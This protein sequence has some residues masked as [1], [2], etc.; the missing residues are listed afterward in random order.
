[1]AALTRKKRTS[2]DV[3]VNLTYYSFSAFLSDVFE[4]QIIASIFILFALVGFA[5]KEYVAAQAD[6]IAPEP[7]PMRPRPP[8]LPQNNN[9]N[10]NI[11][12]RV[13]PRLHPPAQRIQQPA[14]Q[15][16]QA[17][18]P[19][20]P[21]ARP[22]FIPRPTLVP[23]PPRRPQA[24]RPPTPLELPDAMPVTPPPLPERLTIPLDRKLSDDSDDL[25][26]DLQ[27][28]HIVDKGKARDN[29]QERFRGGAGTS[30]LGSRPDLK[31]SP[32]GRSRESSSNESVIR[33]S[34]SKTPSKSLQDAWNGDF[35]RSSSSSS[36]SSGSSAVAS[37]FLGG[38]TWPTPVKFNAGGSSSSTGTPITF[39]PA[40]INSISQSAL[41]LPIYN[42]FATTYPIIP[43]AIVEPA[44]PPVLPQIVPE[45]LAAPAPAP[46][47]LPAPAVVREDED[48]VVAAG[49]WNA[50]L[51]LIGMTGPIEILLQNAIL[52]LIVLIAAI[53]I[54]AWAP[55]ATGRLVFPIFVSL[56]ARIK[57]LVIRMMT[58][59]QKAIDVLLDPA[60]NA[61]A[62]V[63]T[64]LLRK[65]SVIA[66]LKVM[67]EIRARSGIDLKI[68]QPVV[69]A[70]SNAI[71]AISCLPRDM[72]VYWSCPVNSQ[73]D[74]S[75]FRVLRRP[76]FLLSKLAFFETDR[77]IWGMPETI[78]Y[79]AF[80]YS[81]W[82]F[83]LILIA[84]QQG[85]LKH[86][87]AT[88][89]FTLMKRSLSYTGLAI[90]FAFFISI[91]LG[92][93]PIF[94]GALIDMCTLPIFNSTLEGRLE[95]HQ[96][97]P[98]TSSFLH[99]LVG[100]TFMFNVA[101]YV[102]TLREI[103]R[104]G[105]MWF[106]RDPNDP[107]FHPIN[108]ILERP[109]LVQLRKLFIGS[110]LYA[111]MVIFGVGGFVMSVKCLEFILPAG[112]HPAKIWPLKWEFNESLTEFPIDLLLF[113]FAIPWV[114]HFIQ[115]RPLIRNAIERA[116]R[117]SARFLRLS[118][119][120]FGGFHNDELAEVPGARPIGSQ[121]PYIR[122]PNHDH[123]EVIPNVPVM[124]FMEENEALFGRPNETEA[125]V[126]TNWTKI[127]VP[128]MFWWRL[129]MLVVMQWLYG[130]F[131]SFCVLV[132]PLVIGRYGS[133]YINTWI[134]SKSFG[135]MPK[136]SRLDLPVHDFYSY[137]LGLIVLLALS[138]PLASSKTLLSWLIRESQRAA[139]RA[140]GELVRVERVRTRRTNS[141]EQVPETN[142]LELH[143]DPVAAVHPADASLESR[144]LDFIFDAGNMF[145]L[146]QRWKV[147]AAQWL[148]T[149][150]KAL[151]IALS[152][153]VIIPLLLGI[154]FDLYMM[155]LMRGKQDRFNVYPFLS[156]VAQ[157]WALGAVHEKIIYNLIIIGPETFFRRAIVTARDQGFRNLAVYPLLISVVLPTIGLGLLFMFG[158][159]LYILALYPQSIWNLELK[160]HEIE[161]RLMYPITALIML[162]IMAVRTIILMVKSYIEAVR[163]EE[164][165]L[166]RRLNNL[167]Q[168]T[169][170]QNQ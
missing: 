131:M 31:W 129:V 153:G 58:P 99:W 2:D 111:T 104:P 71:S 138:K 8:P 65:K 116:L 136:S 37:S 19:N 139:K 42:E 81:V 83:Q 122:V 169:P 105:V 74:D 102:G 117:N 77:K 79:V 26:L 137:S 94:C 36:S 141:D 3:E 67:Q 43:P 96:V 53:G 124:I 68:S 157:T 60:A 6:I 21:L 128:N 91:E 143:D 66:A 49:D 107:A 76:G 55:F 62:S 149:I 63:V 22:T 1:M 33:G 17:E 24:H 10:V 12:P 127:R 73:Y 120:I 75:P 114:L 95:F 110:L 5:I 16:M 82:L 39:N 118:S 126:R 165:L 25:E 168:G 130:V 97:F 51:E 18:N 101:I 52:C 7:Q 121:P 151:F 47:P 113:H 61:V 146:S 84:S 164:Y 86:R 134:P 103:V 109:A 38:P 11:P 4:G 123:I 119:Y 35:G 93:F 145:A 28:S 87:Y 46:E 30:F 50:F 112:A 85:W 154:N 54:G 159:W 140:R 115:P 20:P 34:P 162:S 147:S 100:T 166:G 59:T 158:P 23:H 70:T 57:V 45:P 88:T 170:Q 29:E 163:D 78:V 80:G 64:L 41:Q 144:W 69:I 142:E 132:G 9:N 155:S 48:D 56:W 92:V 89:L 148:T 150:G 135:P 160:Q 90:K 27:E 13:P 44:I 133:M 108:D 40:P 167:N 106:V 72:T 14:Q 156:Y 15:P 152:I 161:I 98:W 32:A 125:D